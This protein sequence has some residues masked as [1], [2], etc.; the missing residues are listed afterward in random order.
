[1]SD[2]ISLVNICVNKTLEVYLEK[3]DTHTLQQLKTM[4]HDQRITF[5]EDN[6]ISIYPLNTLLADR[7]TLLNDYPDIISQL[8]TF[9]LTDLHSIINHD[10]DENDK[11]KFPSNTIDTIRSKDVIRLSILMGNCNINMFTETLQNKV[12]STIVMLSFFIEAVN[13]GYNNK[14]Q[15]LINNIKLILPNAT[16]NSVPLFRSRAFNI[17]NNIE[18]SINDT[19]L[20]Q[21]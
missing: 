6:V 1:M 11:N 14:L 5:F 19:I 10:N 13:L 7:Y 2:H 18:H 4:N 20:P 21:L 8:F 15:E 17:I 9:T 12:L 3:C 16:F